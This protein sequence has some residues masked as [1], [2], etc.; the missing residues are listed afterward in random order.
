MVEI[1]AKSNKI[2]YKIVRLISGILLIIL[3]LDTKVCV[4]SFFQSFSFSHLF[5]VETIINSLDVARIMAHVNLFSSFG[6]RVTGYEGCDLAAKY[7]ESFFRNLS[8]IVMI[9]EYSIPIPLDRGGLVKIDHGSHLNSSYKIYQ[10]WPNGGLSCFSGTISGRIVYGGKGSLEELNGLDIKDSIVLLDFNSG[11]NWLNAAKLGAKA[12]IFVE[13]SYTTKYEALSKSC[14]GPFSFPRFY[15][16]RDVGIILKDIADSNGVLS[17]SA[18]MKWEEVKARN[19]IGILPGESAEDVLI[20]SA[21]YDSWSIVPAISRASEDSL[22]ISILLEI[23]RLLANNRHKQTIWFVAYSG[24]WQGNAGAVNFVESI[25]LNSTRKEKYWLQIGIDIS[26]ESYLMDCLYVSSIY[27]SMEPSTGWSVG[28]RG[29]IFALTSTYIARLGWIKRHF[30]SLLNVPVESMNVKEYFPAGVTKLIDL[31]NFGL[32]YESRFGSQ[33]DFYMLDT[34]PSLLA[35]CMAITLRTQYARR[36][37]WLT[38]L[39]QS[40]RWNHI[41][42]QA[43]VIAALIYGLANEDFEQNPPYDYS[44]AS[45][46]RWNTLGTGLSVFGFST[47]RGKTVEFS[48]STGWYEPLSRA[49]VRLQIYESQAENAWPF[50]FRYTFSDEN[51]SFVFH[52]LV[53]YTTWHTDAWKFDDNG[54]IT[55]VVDR[56]FYGTAEGVVGGLRTDIYPISVNSSAI[57]PL[58]KCRQVTL[59]D[60][61]NNVETVGLIIRDYRNPNHN[62]LNSFMVSLGSFAAL[63]GGRGAYGFGLGI[64]SVY[65]KSP[66][67]FLGSYVAADGVI[68]IF[69]REGE[70]LIFT[71]NPNPQKYSWPTIVLTNSSLDNPEGNGFL[72]SNSLAIPATLFQA[73]LDMYRMVSHRYN[74]LAKFNIRIRFAEQMLEKALSYLE[75]ANKSYLKKNYSALYACSYLSIQCSYNAYAFVV[76]PSYRET[77]FSLSFFSILIIAFSIFLEKLVF[78]WRSIKRFTVIFLLMITFFTTYAFVHPA[79]LIMMNSIMAVV[80]VGILLLLFLVISIFTFEIRG[81]LRS[82]SVKLLGEH[83]FEKAGAIP[84]Y[85][86]AISYSIE[87]MRKRPLITVLTMIS[88]VLLAASSIAFASVSYDYIIVKGPAYTGNLP[89]N[90]IL[91]KVLYGFPPERRGAIFDMNTVTYLRYVVGGEYEVSPRVWMYP[92]PQGLRPIAEVIS[93]RGVVYRSSI[94]FLGL[95]QTELHKIFEGYVQGPA[96]FMSGHEC[97]LPREIASFLKVEIGETVYIRGLDD[98][99]TIIGILDVPGQVYDFDGN[100]IFPIDPGFSYDLSLSSIEYPEVITPFSVSPSE[101]I[102]VSW[103]T[104]LERGGFISSISLIPREEKAFSELETTA[105]LITLCTNLPTYVG[106]VSSSYSLQK[107]FTYIIQGWGVM[108]IILLILVTLSVANIMLSSLLSKRKDIMIYSVLG[109]SP[110]KILIIFL[111]EG[112]VLSF[113]GV[114]I[115]YLIG[116]GLNNLLIILKI[117]PPTF[118]FNFVSLSVIL[119]MCLILGAVLLVSLYP[120]I[121]AAKIVTPSLE[122]KWRLS[123]RPVKDIWEIIIPVKMKHFEAIGFLR[124]LHEYYLG[125]GNMKPAFRVLD[126]SEADIQNME[127]KLNV[128]LT[129]VERNIVQEVAFK[130]IKEKDECQFHMTIVRKTGDPK[131]WQ[132]RNR[133]FID[134][135][136]KQFLL[137]KALLPEEKRKYSISF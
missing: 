79:L 41:L 116:Y 18:S 55:H 119:S 118:T 129:P 59:F 1:T 26:S 29:T 113:G 112:C 13:P 20:I 70:R 117:L 61:I 28:T 15:V 77:S 92:Q 48:D 45:P 106:F 11:K 14:L 102:I 93:E 73:A 43:V 134:D 114:L 47:L 36:M 34:E 46:R 99:F 104:A 66:P 90:G 24:H 133:A 111:T 115:G 39:D 9:N 19:I 32:T 127:L 68:S 109:L 52:G 130:A 128:L 108:L 91:I 54:E 3:L 8:L 100:S 35:S 132:S 131:M 74:N 83:T 123:T 27:G 51:G 22:G 98:N 2:N 125:S 96:V 76:M 81:L 71:F 120:G 97:I 16:T 62:Y 21:H 50:A 40:I 72:I 103:E 6:S 31:I 78:G 85:V 110:E 107:F 25:L 17:I 86:H 95:S 80:S 30:E 64:F 75:D 65:S 44:I 126:V 4:N 88:M 124:Y 94:V 60:I 12:V 42:P 37:T 58:F 82:I 135:A 84:I 121:L 49:L 38:P 87:S 137:W 67:V 57:I 105:S 122:R 89:Y 56:G 23:A 33:I 69:V 63:G 10:L 101:C 5:H 7:I 136:R 53:P